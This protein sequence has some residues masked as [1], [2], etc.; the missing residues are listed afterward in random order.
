MKQGKVVYVL[1]WDHS[2]SDRLNSGPI[3]C[4]VYGKVTK[5]DELHFEITHWEVGD[6]HEPDHNEE[7][8]SILKGAIIEMRELEL[9]RYIIRSKK[10]KKTSHTSN[11]RRK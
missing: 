8:Y 9:G 5:E 10:P 4:V 11:K 1:F 3:P 6:T 7:C 2:M